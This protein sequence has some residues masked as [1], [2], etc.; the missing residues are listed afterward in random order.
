M[1][2]GF[3]PTAMTMMYQNMLK[4][5]SR[6]VSPLTPA[7][8]MGNAPAINPNMA[9]RNGMGG[10]GGMGN[11]GGMGGMGMGGMGNMGMMGMMGNMMGGQGGMGMGN[12]GNMG[13]MGNMGM[14]NMGYNNNNMVS[15]PVASK[16]S[17]LILTPGNGRRWK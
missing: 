8:S 5:E 14:G 15:R 11:M 1:G 7:M 17:V 4:S 9:M 10:M 6:Q 16:G 13:G 12:M 3:D 2:G